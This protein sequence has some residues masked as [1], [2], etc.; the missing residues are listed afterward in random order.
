[1]H[2]VLKVL[3]VIL[4]PKGELDLKVLKVLKEPKVVKGQQVRQ[5]GKDFRVQQVFK[6]QL[7]LK[8]LKVIQ[9]LKVTLDHKE[10]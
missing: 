5:E 3:R 9:V 8:V 1:M 10:M 2:K 7:D 4:V 6:D